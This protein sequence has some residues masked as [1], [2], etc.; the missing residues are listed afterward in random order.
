MSRDKKII[1]GIIND[2]THKIFDAKIINKPE[3]EKTMKGITGYTM[4]QIMLEK[5]KVEDE[6]KQDDKLVTAGK[7][8]VK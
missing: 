8:V 1:E 4:Q 5:S 6:K 2:T 3:D 7:K